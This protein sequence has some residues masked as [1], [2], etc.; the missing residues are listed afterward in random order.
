MSQLRQILRYLIMMLLSRGREKELLNNTL[1]Q[2]RLRD[3]T[4]R[5]LMESPYQHG[6]YVRPNGTITFSIE[7]LEVMS[8]KTKLI[9]QDKLGEQLALLPL[10]GV[11]SVVASAQKPLGISEQGSDQL[12][13]F[14]PKL[15]KSSN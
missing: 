6:V 14:F 1:I 5:R 2:E 10:E 11:L 3:V 4:S 9:Y 15:K 12:K 13:T 8:G 7:R